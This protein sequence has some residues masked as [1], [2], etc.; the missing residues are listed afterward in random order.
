M[1]EG[2]NYILNPDFQRRHRWNIQK[3]SKLIESIIMNVPIPPIFL[4][5]KAFSVYEVMDGLQRLTAIKQF[6]KNEFALVDLAEW[7]ELNGK[8]YRELPDQVQKGIDRR[9]IS[10]IIILQET[11]KDA[12]EAQRLKQLVFERINSGGEKLAGQE[13]RNAIYNGELN[14]VCIKLA[15]NI[16]FCELWEIPKPTPEEADPNADLPENL[17]M[18]PLFSKMEDAELVLRFF[19]YRQIEK[20]QSTILEEF[21][22][23]Y[24]QEANKFNEETI[25][26]LETIFNNTIEFAHNLF[27]KK[28][29]WIYRKRREKESRKIKWSFYEKSSKTIYDPMM[30]VLSTLH[31]KQGILIKRRNEIIESMPDF[32]MRNYASFEGRSSN[33]NDVIKRINLLYKHIDKFST[34]AE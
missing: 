25:N 22:D 6:Y 9:Y 19:A 14:K 20:W 7:P 18:N 5:E 17:I 1:V 21:L 28:A 29:F 27:G 32:Y 15:R 30:Y 34:V 3:K 24:L 31:E 4:Y 10:S 13:T 12:T 11:A 2:P 23:N 16:T 33:R 8:T 26:E